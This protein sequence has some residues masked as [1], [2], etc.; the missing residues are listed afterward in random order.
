MN[1]QTIRL[2]MNIDDRLPICPDCGVEKDW[3]EPKELVCECKPKGTA[4]HC[5]SCGDDWDIELDG[6][7]SC[8]DEKPFGKRD[9]DKEK[10]KKFFDSFVGRQT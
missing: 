7:C 4:R 1:I 5:D 6:G 8:K 10:L 9:E 3:S 2:K